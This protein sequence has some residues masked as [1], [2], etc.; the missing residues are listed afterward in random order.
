VTTVPPPPRHER[1][2]QVA[3]RLSVVALAVPVLLFTGSSRVIASGLHLAPNPAAN[4]TPSPNFEYSGTCSGTTGD[5]QCANPCVTTSLTFPPHS[6]APSC[7]DYVLAAL[8]A[9]RAGEHLDAISLPTNWFSLS[10]PE[11]L[12]VLANLERT[13]RGL[14]PYLGLNATL[15]VAAQRA[16]STD[17][18]PRLAAGFA[19][20]HSSDGMARMG[21]AWASGM[22]TLGAD[23][24]WMYADGWGGT[25]TSTPNT[26]CTSPSAA[27]CWAHRDELLGAGSH[28]SASV[29]L[30]C[31][32]C[33]M[34][35]GFAVRGGTG[36][37]ADLLERPAHGAPAM[38]FTWARDVVPYL[39][40]SL[41]YRQRLASRAQTD[42]RRAS[43]HGAWPQWN[44]RGTAATPCLSPL[45]ESPT[46][47]TTCRAKT[48]KRAGK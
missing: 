1:T 39:A 19:V 16:A 40:S 15:S 30:D 47:M 17:T 12:F 46:G 25:A 28:F 42:A 32:D 23:F 7:V 21:G 20:A 48:F 10:D 22:T 6:D 26:A 43:V 24:L 4:V 37:Y 5:W 13:A 31:S 33:E 34:G 8:D 45:V 14:H 9:A 29:G 3:V 36:S 2:R 27:G 35:T 41:A 44:E 11:Q 18:D 38:T